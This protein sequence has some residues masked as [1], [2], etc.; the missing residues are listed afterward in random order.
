MGNNIYKFIFYLMIFASFES[1]GGLMFINSQYYAPAVESEIVVSP[2]LLVIIVPGIPDIL[3]S[4]GT[5]FYSN[6]P[7]PGD[8][9]IS[10]VLFNPF[11]GG[12]DFV[13][14]YNNSGREIELADMYIASRDKTL[15]FKEI[16]PLSDKSETLIDARYAAFTS[17]RSILLSN[18]NSNC[19]DCIFNM[20]KFPA[21]NLDEGWVVLLNKNMEIIDEFHYL[22]SMHHPLIN[23][24]KGISLERNSFSKPADDPSNWHSASKAVG[25][26]TPGYRNSTAEIGAGDIRMVTFEPKIFSPND[27]GVNDVLLIKL[28]PGEP[29]LIVNIRIYNDSGLEIRRLTNNQLIGTQDIIEWDGTKENHQKADLGIYIIKVELFGLQSGKK[30][31][32]TAC[33]L[34]DRLE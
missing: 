3:T 12:V 16:Y 34:T 1:K 25:F 7:E 15:K 5:S 14:I 10:E 28:S 17:D 23:D 32:K 2:A 9:L 27:D 33:V 30:L 13:E 24:V 4:S 26:A 21:Y 18:Y 29:G 11:S 20:V 8:L 19:P 31:F 6:L 22:E